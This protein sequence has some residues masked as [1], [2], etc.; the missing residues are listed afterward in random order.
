MYEMTCNGPKAPN[1]LERVDVRY[2]VIS[3]FTVERKFKT[4]IF[5]Q[6]T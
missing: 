6:I 4:S 2:K 3:A 1:S 5:R